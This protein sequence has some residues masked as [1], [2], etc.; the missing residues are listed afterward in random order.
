MY[1]SVC[2]AQRER[3]IILPSLCSLCV[4]LNRP[5]TFWSLQV[6]YKGVLF[7]DAHSRSGALELQPMPFHTERLYLRAVG[8]TVVVAA[9]ASPSPWC[10]SPD[11]VVPVKRSPS[12]RRLLTASLSPPPP[13]L[14]HH[15]TAEEYCGYVTVSVQSTLL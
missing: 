4:R 11:I 3:E 14:S 15:G 9:S 8:P 7:D 6:F 2:F 5:R 10:E 12:D 1:S 13:R